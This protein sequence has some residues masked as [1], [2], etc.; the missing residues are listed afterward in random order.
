MN[1]KI[2]LFALAIL[3][4]S[5]CMATETGI[6]SVY[7]YGRTANGERVSPR[8]LTGAHRTLAFGTSVR[9]THRRTGRSM[10]VRIN[11]RGPQIRGRVVDLTPAAANVLG[12]DGLAAVVLEV[13]G[14][15]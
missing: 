6:A 8:A 10:V 4:P 14:H 2:A 3:I 12:F 15:Q 9:V 5:H 13:V 7:S 11:D 1:I